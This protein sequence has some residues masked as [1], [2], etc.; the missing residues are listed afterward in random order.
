ME[1]KF[2]KW[3]VSALAKQI[4][5]NRDT[6]DKARRRGS[7]STRTAKK[8]ELTTGV[9]RLRFLY[10]DEYGDPWAEIID[11]REREFLN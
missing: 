11:L 9:D 7:T 2:K 5:V 6:L 4:G 10:P 8:L 3:R 1:A